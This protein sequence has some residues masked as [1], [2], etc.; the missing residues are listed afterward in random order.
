MPLVLPSTPTFI[1]AR[2]G[3]VVCL[4]SADYKINTTLTNANYSSREFGFVWTARRGL[5]CVC[6]I[7]LIVLDDFAGTL[8]EHARLC[9]K[10]VLRNEGRESGLNT[11]RVF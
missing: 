4:L 7:D 9:K 5:L 1:C 6:V 8:N 11:S 3:R 10:S 2:C